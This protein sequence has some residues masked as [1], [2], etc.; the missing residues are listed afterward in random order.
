MFLLHMI[1]NQQLVLDDHRLHE[2][3]LYVNV[4]GGEIQVLKISLIEPRT[5]FEH[6]VY[7]PVYQVSS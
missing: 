4:V 1:L 6:L 2:C 3:M 7:K 5:Y